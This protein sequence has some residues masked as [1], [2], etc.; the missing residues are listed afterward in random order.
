VIRFV[1]VFWRESAFGA[2]TLCSNSTSI[3][4]IV[5]SLQWILLRGQMFGEVGFTLWN[6]VVPETE[7]R[8]S[9]KEEAL[10]TL[11][12]AASQWNKSIC[13]LCRL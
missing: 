5:R 2:C 1:P 6:S 9:L 12:D 8:I 3:A 4:E 7:K 13:R 11:T 10:K